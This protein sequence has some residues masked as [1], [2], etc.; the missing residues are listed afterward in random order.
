MSGVVDPLDAGR[1][2]EA[3][4]SM[5]LPWQV[6]V[7]QET[8]S[9]N[10]WLRDWGR[11]EDCANQVILAEAQ[12]AGRGRRDHVWAAEPGQDLTF[13]L[14]VR[15]QALLEKWPRLTQ[16]TA[17]AVCRVLAELT[18]LH[19]VIKWPNDVHVR[20]KKICGILTESFNG[21]SGRFLVIGVGL[22]VRR[23]HFDGD[24]ASIATSLA[25]ELAPRVAPSRNELVEALLAEL[26]AAFARALS[27]AT[28]PSLLDEVRA[29][30]SLAGRRV[31]LGT[32]A[33]ECAGMAAGLDDEGALLLDL[34]DG[35][36]TV[37][38]SAEQV[39][40]M[41]GVPPCDF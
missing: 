29:R 2:Q 11:L 40:A 32:A 23:Q 36:R 38:S 9:T 17:L 31:T 26:T 27:D 28:F 13:S 21:V 5:G 15:P 19:A 1:L 7:L 8:A 33:G 37:I 14:A 18:G 3:C 12:T 25:L 22:N 4:A 39:R 10:D 24:L 6:R 41:D 20:G 16:A 34:A 30:D 35:T